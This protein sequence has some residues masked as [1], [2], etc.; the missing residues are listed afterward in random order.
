MPLLPVRLALIPTAR[1]NLYQRTD[2]REQAQEQLATATTMYRE[3][4]GVLAGEGGGGGDN[5]G[6]IDRP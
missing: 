6:R 4:H 3:R 1:G 5:A 2:K